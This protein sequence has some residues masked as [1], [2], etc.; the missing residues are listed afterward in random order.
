M[1]TEEG[2]E[3]VDHQTKFHQ[4]QSSIQGQRKR[5][6]STILCFGSILMLG[7]E[8]TGAREREGEAWGVGLSFKKANVE[9]LNM[10]GWGVEG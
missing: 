5:Q 10:K 7:Q 1:C 6:S 2:L 3:V 9:S 8:G 4:G